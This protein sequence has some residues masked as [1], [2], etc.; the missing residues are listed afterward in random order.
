VLR[1]LMRVIQSER[2]QD[3]PETE[4]PRWQKGDV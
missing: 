2:A 4:D 3:E 1:A